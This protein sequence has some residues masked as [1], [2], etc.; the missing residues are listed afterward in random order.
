MLK[1][2]EAI[3]RRS[4]RPVEKLLADNGEWPVTFSADNWNPDNSIKWQEV[5]ENF[6]KRTGVSSLFDVTVEIDRANI[7]RRVITVISS[8][9]L[10][11]LNDDDNVNESDDCDN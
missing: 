4:L 2:I 7:S 8:F 11:S 10:P 3:S 1:K 5:H 6:A 9:Q